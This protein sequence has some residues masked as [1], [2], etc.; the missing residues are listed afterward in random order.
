MSN[1]PEYHKPALSYKEQVNRL[2]ERG[3]HIPSK[4]KATQLLENL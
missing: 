2:K 3:L 1:K 4:V